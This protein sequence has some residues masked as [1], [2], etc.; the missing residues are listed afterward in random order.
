VLKLYCPETFVIDVVFKV[1]G[2]AGVPEI[3]V[4]D[5]SVTNC[6]QTTNFMLG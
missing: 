5:P 6:L 3:L 2:P 4:L 1:Q